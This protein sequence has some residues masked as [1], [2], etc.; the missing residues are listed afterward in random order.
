[1]TNLNAAKGTRP[2][3]RRQNNSDRS[4]S[5][6]ADDRPL[7]TDAAGLREPHRGRLIWD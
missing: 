2:M 6:T 3:P 5:G 1:M 4:P 7:A